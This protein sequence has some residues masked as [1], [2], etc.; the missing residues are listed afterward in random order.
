MFF[1]VF[2]CRGLVPRLLGEVITIWLANTLTYVV[3]THLAPKSPGSPDMKNYTS[4]VF[5]LIVTQLTYPF[6]VV[7]NNMIVS[8][9][10]SV[11]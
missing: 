1:G 11:I 2:F 4:A 6:S 3:N 7:S 5:S 8:G 10:G 9:S